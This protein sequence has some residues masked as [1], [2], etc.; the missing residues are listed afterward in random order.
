MHDSHMVDIVASV[1]SVTQ[2][3]LSMGMHIPTNGIAEICIY[4]GQMMAIIMVKI[5]E[6]YPI[7]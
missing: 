6:H 5:Y 7:F 3:I 1:A 2:L 4:I